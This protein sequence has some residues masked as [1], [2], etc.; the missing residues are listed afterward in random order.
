MLRS[1]L[2]LWIGIYRIIHPVFRSKLYYL[3]KAISSKFSRGKILDFR[4]RDSR[5]N[6]RSYVDHFTFS[7]KK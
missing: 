6:K 4:I 7:T 5:R 2:L 3:S 1:K